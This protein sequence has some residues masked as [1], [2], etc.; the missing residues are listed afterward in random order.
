MHGNPHMPAAARIID[1]RSCQMVS[2]AQ[3][4]IQHASAP[5][6]GPCVLTVPI[7]A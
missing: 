6:S 5:S 1:M 3:S 2:L 4:P 7:G